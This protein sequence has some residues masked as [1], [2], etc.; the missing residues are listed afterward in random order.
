MIMKTTAAVVARPT[1]S[2]PPR[3]PKPMWTEMSGMMKPK[4]NPLVIE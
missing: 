4:T 2:A 1:P 3:V